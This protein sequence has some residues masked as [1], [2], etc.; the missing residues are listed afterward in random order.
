[1]HA[2]GLHFWC[3]IVDC[4]VWFLLRRI[5]NEQWNKNTST[6]TTIT[7]EHVCT[8]IINHK[9]HKS[10]GGTVQKY[11]YGR[12]N[13]SQIQFL[14]VCV[15]QFPTTSS[16]GFLCSLFMCKNNIICHVLHFVII[17]VCVVCQSFRQLFDLSFLIIVCWCPCVIFDFDYSFVICHCSC[18]IMEPAR[19]AGGCQCWCAWCQYNA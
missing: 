1:M 3:V 19:C 12:I 8:I 6:N 10:L 4:A 9:Q 14:K 15:W 13:K 5:N 18:W 11:K 2:P 17:D 7:N 16:R